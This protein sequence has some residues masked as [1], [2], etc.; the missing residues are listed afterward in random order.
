[1]FPCSGSPHLVNVT[2]TPLDWSVSQV[3]TFLH[4]VLRQTAEQILMVVLL[5]VVEQSFIQDGIPAT[6]TPTFD[7]ARSSGVM[8]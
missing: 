1:M 8:S 6:S 2:L 4:L 3:E 7:S 5:F